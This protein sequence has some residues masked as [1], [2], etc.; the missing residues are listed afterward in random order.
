MNNQAKSP[1]SKKWGFFFLLFLAPSLI[2]LAFY[3]K[4]VRKPL[5]GNKDNFFVRLPVIG[6][7]EFNG[8]D[9]IYHT[10][11]PFELL[12]QDSTSF[13]S[14]ELKGKNYIANFFFVTCKTI[15]PKMSGSLFTVQTR[16]K[17]FKNL[18]ILSFT[19]NPENDT[20]TVLKEYSK[21]VHSDPKV[22]TFLTGPKKEIYELA[23]TSYLLN[24]GEGDGG[25]DDFIHSELFVLVD[26]EGKIRGMYDG[27]STVDVNRLIDEYKVL[28]VEYRFKEKK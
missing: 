22:W 14:E 27:T 11:K 24:A 10:V 8:K 21:K 13:T 3:V 19:V 5:S 15:C 25:P 23:R 28:D 12:D 4:Y 18:R 20:P 9:T 17:H 2:C 6:P 7:R 1:L 16:L 26:K